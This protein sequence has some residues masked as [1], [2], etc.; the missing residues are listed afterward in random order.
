[1]TTPTHSIHH[2]AAEGYQANADRY[3]KGRPDYP[4]EIADWLRDVIGLHAGTPA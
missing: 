3:V 4:P 2:A 1:M